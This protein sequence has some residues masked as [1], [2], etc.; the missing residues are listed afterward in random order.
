MKNLLL[1]LLLSFTLSC[2][3]FYRTP[4][5]ENVK[6]TEAGAVITT[7]A[8]TILKQS[9]LTEQIAKVGAKE[10]QEPTSK[11]KFTT[12]AVIQS[13]SIQPAAE[14]IKELGQVIIDKNKGEI[15]ISL[16]FRLLMYALALGLI[17]SILSYFGLNGFIKSLIKAALSPAQNALDNITEKVTTQQKIVTDVADTVAKQAYHSDV[18]NS[19]F[20]RGIRERMINREEIPEKTK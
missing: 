9:R 19:A 1:L 12:I 8:D 18:P 2:K 11:D 10:T 15:K 16:T 7:N 3:T 17:M 5:V 6:M 4:T 14:T 13:D 20:P